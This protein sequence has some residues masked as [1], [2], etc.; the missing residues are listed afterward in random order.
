MPLIRTSL[1]WRGFL[2]SGLFT[3][4]INIQGN[5]IP[6]LRDE[7]QLSYATVSLHPSALAAGMI[8]TGLFTETLVAA[9][10]RRWSCLIGVAGCIVGLLTICMAANAAASIA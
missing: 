7:L 9:I 6:F 4:I 2:L 3:F 5:I 1:T 8:A 10:G